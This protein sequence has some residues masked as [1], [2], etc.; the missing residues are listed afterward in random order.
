[1]KIAS[2]SKF[3]VWYAKEYLLNVFLFIDLLRGLCNCL[4]IF[5]FFFKFER[6]GYLAIV[7]E[8]KTVYICKKKSI[9]EVVLI[10][11]TMQ[12]LGNFQCR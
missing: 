2:K 1:M 9:K 5:F 11:F 12:R 4:S 7:L 3:E 10:F 8:F 6:S